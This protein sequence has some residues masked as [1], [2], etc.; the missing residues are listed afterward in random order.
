VPVTTIDIT[1]DWGAALG[2]VDGLSDIEEWSLAVVLAVGEDGAQL[3]LMPPR[4]AFARAV[5]RT[6]DRIHAGIGD[7]MGWV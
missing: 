3:G 6:S 2:E 1:Q 4:L 5:R 7:G